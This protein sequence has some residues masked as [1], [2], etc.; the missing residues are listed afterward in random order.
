M[1]NANVPGKTITKTVKNALDPTKKSDANIVPHPSIPALTTAKTTADNGASQNIVAKGF[2]SPIDC[3]C[4][5]VSVRAQRRPDS[6]EAE[7]TM[8][9]PGMLTDVVSRTMRK[10][11]KVMRE[12]TR[13]S[14]S[15]YFSRRKRKA[16]MRTK[17]RVEDLHMAES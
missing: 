8:M 6:A 13:M 14:R 3:L 10:T 15:E 7:N 2:D 12:M 4:M 9:I 5:T 11:P 16:N 1:A 17:M